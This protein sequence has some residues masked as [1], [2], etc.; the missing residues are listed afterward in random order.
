[1]TILD[2][3]NKVVAHLGDNPDPEKRGKNPIPPEQWKDGE[4]ISPHCP[5]WDAQGNLYVLEWLSEGRIT[6]LK[7][8]G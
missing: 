4:F 5:R 2:K 8:V 7:R 3:N 6:K 1:M